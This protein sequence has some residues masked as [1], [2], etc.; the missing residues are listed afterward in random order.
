MTKTNGILEWATQHNCEF[1]IDKFQLLDLTKHTVPH[2][3]SKNK[4]VPIPRPA[5][6]IGTHRIT[7]KDMAKFLGVIINSKLSWKN[8]AAAALAKG[9]DWLSRIRRI[10]KATKGT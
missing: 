4:R 10:A 7:S 1:G 2:P 8:Q 6:K 9:Q 3:F 5:L